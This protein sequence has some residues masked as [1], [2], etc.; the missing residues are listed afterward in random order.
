M[1][2]MIFSGPPPPPPACSSTR[3]PSH[4]PSAAAS[5]VK[6]MPSSAYTENEASRTQV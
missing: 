2:Y 1:R 6:P 3:S 5:S 4:W